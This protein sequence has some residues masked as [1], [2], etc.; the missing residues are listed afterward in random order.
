M[1]LYNDVLQ[2]SQLVYG[3]HTEHLNINNII[4]FTVF[5]K[6]EVIVS[7]GLFRMEKVLLSTY[8]RFLGRRK[9]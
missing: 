5:R 3:D 7:C 4:V 2:E 1:K 9:T 6:E 8:L